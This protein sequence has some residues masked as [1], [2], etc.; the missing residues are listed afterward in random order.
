MPLFE[1]WRV[2][3]HQLVAE[4]PEVLESR[5]PV[6]A[7][8]GTTPISEVADRTHCRVSGLI[9]AVVIG[10][11]GQGQGFELDLFDGSGTLNA[12]WLGR[13]EI[14]GLVT[15]RHI[16]VEGLATVGADGR[17]VMLNPRY[18]L[19]PGQEAL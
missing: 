19:L 18:E 3:A 16:V 5:Q 11:P 10:V 4:P 15:G 14:P 13:R 6:S 12:L 2:A 1:R 9:R 17:R 7:R 8:F